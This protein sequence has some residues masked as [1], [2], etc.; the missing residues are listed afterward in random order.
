MD[1]LK[2][3]NNFLEALNPNSLRVINCA[4][5][6]PLLSD[7]KNEIFQFERLGYFKR[8]NKISNDRKN[9]FIRLVTLRDSWA[10]Y[11]KEN[12]K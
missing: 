4:K 3:N 1:F 2:E 8:D 6:E 7:P 11:L 9:I 12:I 10:R 5:L